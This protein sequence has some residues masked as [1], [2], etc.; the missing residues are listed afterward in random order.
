MTTPY[1]MAD[2]RESNESDD[3]IG[4]LDAHTPSNWSS[5]KLRGRCSVHRGSNGRHSSRC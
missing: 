5:C 3:Q 1:G 2:R 4:A